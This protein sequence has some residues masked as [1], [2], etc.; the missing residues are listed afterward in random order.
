MLRPKC[1]QPKWVDGYIC[2]T[3]P[4]PK[5]LCAIR[6]LLRRLELTLSGLAV[7]FYYMGKMRCVQQVAVSRVRWSAS[8]SSNIRQLFQSA[9]SGGAGECCY[10]PLHPCNQHTFPCQL[11][12]TYISLC[13]LESC[14][15]SWPNWC[16]HLV[17]VRTVTK[18][19]KE[20]LCLLGVGI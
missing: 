10:W 7:A 2:Y 11:I 18:C 8:R 19:H 20:Y 12:S 16:W 1:S 4:H 14:F 5:P 15:N 13:H 17:P 6:S 3:F 9:N